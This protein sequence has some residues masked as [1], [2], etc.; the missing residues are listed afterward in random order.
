MT[1]LASVGTADVAFSESAQTVLN[2]IAA[3]IMFSVALELKPADLARV[4]RRPLAILVGVVA[5]FLLL[6]ALSVLLVRPLDVRPSIALG[7]ILVACCPP[8]KISNLLTLQSH[9][10]TALSVSMTFA[11]N[12]VSLVA[13][14]FAFPFWVGFDSDADALLSDIDVSTGSVLVEVLL[15]IALPLALGLLVATRAPALAARFRPWLVPRLFSVTM[16]R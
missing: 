13:L 9:G 14:P 11:S 1:L 15:V 4:V 10:D 16:Y 5:Q 8:G 6:P 3:V 12:L 2:V 7:M